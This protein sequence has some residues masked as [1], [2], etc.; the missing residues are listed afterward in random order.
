MIHL[1]KVAPSVICLDCARLGEEVAA[2]E[3][4]GADFLHLDIMDGHFVPNLTFGPLIAKALRPLTRL[5]LHAHLMVSRPD[6][7]LAPF[8]EAGVDAL[9]VHFEGAIHLHRTLTHIRELGCKTGVALN[10]H[11]PVT[12]LEEVLPLVDEVLVMTVN[13]GFAGQQQIT[14]CLHKIA[15]LVALRR[16]LGLEFQVAVD[17]GIK[18]SNAAEVRR[19]GADVLVVGT[20][21][22]AS[23]LSYAETIAALRG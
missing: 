12:A 1:V 19:L 14:S 9:T 18:L 2:L 5:E 23:G 17:G 4:A 22:T 11:T 13:P 20:G 15:D 6:T 21:L 16:E 3:K 8:A 7:L 10:P